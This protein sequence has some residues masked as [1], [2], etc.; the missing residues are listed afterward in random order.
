MQPEETNAIEVEETLLPLID[1][2]GEVLAEDFK[3]DE[4]M[5]EEN[6]PVSAESDVEEGETNE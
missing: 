1:E 5:G 4:D 6:L 2:N 3:N